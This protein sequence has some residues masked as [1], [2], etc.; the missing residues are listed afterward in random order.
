MERRRVKSK[1][2][3]VK[4]SRKKKVLIFLFLLLIML[5]ALVMKFIILDTYVPMKQVQQENITILTIGTDANEYR[6]ELWSDSKAP[7]T[8]SLMVWTFNP[9]TMKI[10]TTSIP[11]D[12]SVDYV[13]PDNTG[14][15]D[16]QDQINELY[17]LSGY[18]VSCLEATINNLLNVEIDYYVLVNMDSVENII[19]MVGPITITAHAQDGVLYQS[20]VN[21]YNSYTWYD[22]ESYDMSGDE[23]VSYA[24]ARHDSEKD[25]G[26]GLRQQQVIT[27]TLKS[28]ADNGFNVELLREMFNLVSTDIDFGVIYQYA[29][30][31][32]KIDEYLNLMKNHEPLNSELFSNSVWKSIFDYYGFEATVVSDKSLAEFQTYYY[33]NYTEENLKEYF[34]TSYQFYNEAYS[35]HYNIVEEQLQE[36]SD[37]LRS[38]LGLESETVQ[39]PEKDYGDNEASG[40]IPMEWASM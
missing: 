36:I 31:G 25:Y 11:R 21:S 9:T 26:R 4:K 17:Y 29:T 38:N 1:Q 19:D 18:D 12:T 32:A 13:C 16:Y 3:K 2:K 10:V 30:Y 28:I 20:S 24:R 23:A 39:V 6:E 14:V 15:P 33:E 7:L 40:L 37:A 34:V 35:G 22:G 8:D 5:I 27:A